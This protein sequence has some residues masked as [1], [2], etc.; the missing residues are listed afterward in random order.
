MN[1][2]SQA[3]INLWAK[4]LAAEGMLSWLPL[5]VH[6]A[7]SAFIAQK[8]WN[9]WLPEGAKTAIEQSVAG[10]GRAEQL[11]IFLAAAH[12]IGKATPVFQAKQVWPPGKDLDE[13]LADRLLAAGLPIKP[14]N[15]FTRAA[16]TPHALASQILLVSNVIRTASKKKTKKF[17]P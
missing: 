17:R 15:E 10:P 14:H 8:L 11:F 7:D 16:K 4:K 2:L 13:N 12:D 1:K 6:L 3:T 9:D 5:T